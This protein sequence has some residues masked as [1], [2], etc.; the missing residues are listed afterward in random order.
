MA[1]VIKALN[2][3]PVDVLGHAY[4]NKTARCL[5]ADYPEL[6]KRVILLAAGGEVP[7]DPVAFA[8]L[9]SAVTEN[10]SDSEWLSAMHKSHFFGACDPNI[11]RSGWYPDIAVAQLSI[12]KSTPNENWW[13]A[14]TVPMLIIQGLD[15]L[16]A[17]PT[18]EGHLLT[19][20]I[21]TLELTITG[22]ALAFGFGAVHA[23]TPGHGKTIVTTYLVG[24]NSTFRHALLLSVVTTITHTLSI[25]LLGLIVLFASNYLLPE[26]LYFVFS[27]ISGIAICCIGFWQL[28]NYFNPTHHHHHIDKEQTTDLI[29]LGMAG[30][31][32]PCSEALIL[33]LGAIALHKTTYGILLVLTFSLGLASVLTAIGAV[34]VYSQQWL[35]RLPKFDSLQTHL[36]LISAVA[37]SITGLIIT[38][39]TII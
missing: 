1:R 20:Q 23:L 22:L 8:A 9:K 16:L 5:A 6:V 13:Q 36:P 34:A 37:I 4:G 19:Q 25:F 30:G 12:S 3:S 24:S 28:E 32:I 39:K 10:L 29:T 15:D 17:P 18:N 33:L 27:L 26:Q 35:D 2:V 31:L 11:W 21:L 7:S 14:G 38:T